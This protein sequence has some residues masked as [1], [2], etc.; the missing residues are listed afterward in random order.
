MANE[1]DPPWYNLIIEFFVSFSK[2]NYTTVYYL[3]HL[4]AT[5]TDPKSGN[6]CKYSPFSLTPS[7]NLLSTFPPTDPPHICSQHTYTHTSFLSP[8]QSRF[9]D[10]SSEDGGKLS[11]TFIPWGNTAVNCKDLTSFKKHRAWTLRSRCIAK[12]KRWVK[13]NYWQ[14]RL[15]FLWISML[16][17]NSELVFHQKEK[18]QVEWINWAENCGEERR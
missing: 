13:N 15:L 9:R 3:D 10:K 18:P 1:H 4:M 2:Q 11:L 17:C 16:K 12:K 14:S 8:V 5:I 6:T 7:R